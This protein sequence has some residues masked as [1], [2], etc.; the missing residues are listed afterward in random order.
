[1]AEKKQKQDRLVPAELAKFSGPLYRP[2]VPY[3]WVMTYGWGIVGFYV[4]HDDPLHILVAH[5]NYFLR[6]GKDY[7]RLAREGGGE[8]TSWCYRGTS[9]LTV[10]QIIH[11]CEYFGEVPRAAIRLR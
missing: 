6:A 3:Q 5:A 2:C 1:M 11:V 8:E 9:L 7:G 10:P 4:R